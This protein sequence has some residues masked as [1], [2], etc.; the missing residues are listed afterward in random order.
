MDHVNSKT[1]PIGG[2]ARNIHDN[3]D[4]EATTLKQPTP[5]DVGSPTPCPAAHHLQ[6]PAPPCDE[7]DRKSGQSGTVAAAPPSLDLPEGA[8][9]AVA[10]PGGFHHG[11]IQ[12]M[13]PILRL[14]V[15]NPGGKGIT[16]A[17]RTLQLSKPR[18]KPTSGVIILSLVVPR[19]HY[20]PLI[21]QSLRIQA[22]HLSVYPPQAPRY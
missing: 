5:A 18:S 9:R 6:M 2:N 14:K 8:V 21:L 3:S 10:W 17:L 4:E 13:F 12:E 11:P 15:D 1:K 16:A 22:L 7:L 20:C 19:I